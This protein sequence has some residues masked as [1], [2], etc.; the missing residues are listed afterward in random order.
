MKNLLELL[1]ILSFIVA[2]GALA[3]TTMGMMAATDV[4]PDPAA[5]ADRAAGATRALVIAVVAIGVYI[6]ARVLR[7]R[8]D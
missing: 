6:A 5:R 3:W 4:T 2:F 8:M 7:K 1:T